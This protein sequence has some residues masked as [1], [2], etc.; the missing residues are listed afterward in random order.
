MA[1]IIKGF[2]SWWLALGCLWVKLHLNINKN[3][4]IHMPASESHYA[5]RIGRYDGRDV[6]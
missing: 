4:L 6:G 3:I 1:S 5:A 2:F